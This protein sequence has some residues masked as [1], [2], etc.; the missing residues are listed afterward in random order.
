EAVTINGASQPDFS[1]FPVVE[2]NGT[3]AGSANGLTINTGNSLVRGLAIN[4]FSGHGIVLAGDGNILEGN[5][6]GTNS[7]GTFALSNAMDGVFIN[8]GSGN[9]IGGTTSAARN[10]LS[11]NRNGIQI[12][13]AGVSNQVRGNFI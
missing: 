12:F 8:G 13:G 1:G 5:F 2:L 7:I 9:L 10:L 11:G 4:R 3:S 6:I